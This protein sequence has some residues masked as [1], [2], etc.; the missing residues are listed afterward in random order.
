MS[1]GF[2]SQ[3]QLADIGELVGPVA[4]EVNNF[5]NTVLLHLAVLE[6][7]YPDLSEDLVEIRRQGSVTASLTRQLQGYLHQLPPSPDALVDVNQVLRKTVDDF[8]ERD[9]RPIHLQL[10]PAPALFQGPS[11]DFNRLCRFLL[12]NMVAGEDGKLIQ[13]TVS[14]GQITV[15][16]EET[17]TTLSESALLHFFEAAGPRRPGVNHLE[18]AACQRMTQRLHGSL[19]VENRRA[20]SVAIVLE[21]P[22][23]P[24]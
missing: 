24:T 12:N 8:K 21:L 11:S 22:L 9:R 10:T 23:A 13:T 18:L 17:G 1:E 4:H 5:L 14:D 6:Q 2:T 7:Q 19:R 15:V 20:Q 3:D 16:F